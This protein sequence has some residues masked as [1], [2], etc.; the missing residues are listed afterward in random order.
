MRA[1][2]WGRIVNIAS[3][4]GLVGSAGKSAYVAAKHGLVGLTKVTALETAGTGVTCN[5]ICPGFVL[6]PPAAQQIADIA[7]ADG[8]SA[9]AAAGPAAG[10]QAAAS[11]QFVTPRQL[12]GIVTMLCSP[13]GDEVRGASSGGGR[14]L[15]SPRQGGKS[16][17][18]AGG[19]GREGARALAAP[20]QCFTTIHVRM[21]WRFGVHRDRLNLGTCASRTRDLPHSVRRHR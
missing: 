18:K 1:R 4:H 16:G 3:V 2:N 6:T 8:I 5:A 13:L 17:Q 20:R 19:G 21:P 7:R 14:R 11:G 12:G 15:D 9:E 10:G